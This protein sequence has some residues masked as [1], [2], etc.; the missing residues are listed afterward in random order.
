M[1]Y[2]RIFLEVRGNMKKLDNQELIK[3]L[4][5]E[6]E[7]YERKISK[8]EKEIEIL[9]EKEYEDKKEKI[10]ELNNLINQEIGNTRKIKKTQK[11]SLNFGTVGLTLFFLSIV[12]T[13]IIGDFGLSILW[14]SVIS[15]TCLVE[16]VVSDII[17]RKANKKEIIS[18]TKRVKLQNE[19]Y[20]LE[21]KK[22][23]HLIKLINKNK[24]LNSELKTIKEEL[25]ILLKYETMI[26]NAE[27]RYNKQTKT[28]KKTNKS[29]DNELVK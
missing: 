12:A 15:A 1:L 5:K 28:K 21:H 7:K 27:K 3:L 17:L 23:E 22:S 11:I 29:N 26:I 8:T 24:K 18:D 16:V 19:Q 25:K 20:D 10:A 4:D 9:K 13:F 6:I 2:D 14:P